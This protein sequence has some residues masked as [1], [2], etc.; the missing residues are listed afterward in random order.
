[1]DPGV[2]EEEEPLD[3]TCAMNFRIIANIFIYI[4]N[5]GSLIYKYI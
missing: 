2:V 5:L 3:L 4:T 1:M